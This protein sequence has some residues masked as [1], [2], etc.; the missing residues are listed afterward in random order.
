MTDEQIDITA[1]SVDKLSRKLLKPHYDS[2]SSH[3]IQYSIEVAAK[4]IAAGMISAALNK[5]AEKL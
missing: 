1:D 4:L 5:L 3:E 2:T